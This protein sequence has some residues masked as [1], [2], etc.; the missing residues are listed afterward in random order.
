MATPTPEQLAAV[1][2][3]CFNDHYGIK[4][5]TGVPLDFKNHA[6]LWEPYSDNSPKLVCMK[7]AQIGFSTMAINKS[8]WATKNLGLDTIYT[9]P[10]SNDVKDF[11]S[12]K[13]NRII[14]HNPIFLKWVKDK[15][16][17]E[18]KSIDGFTIYY[19]GCVDE[20]TEVLTKKGWKKHNEVKIG[21]SLY[22]YNLDT[23]SLEEDSIIDLTVFDT[24]EDVV[25]LESNSIDALIT[26]DHRCVVINRNGKAKIQRAHELK[27]GS[28]NYIPI[29]SKGLEKKESSFSNNA[30]VRVLGW[31]ITEGSYWNCRNKSTFVRKDGT[32]NDKVYETPRVSI[33]Q[34]NHC[35][36][37]E[38]DLF[39]AGITY[40][41]VLRK[42]GTY[43]YKLNSKHSKDVVELLP[44]KE[45][46]IDFI[47]SLNTQ[48]MNELIDVMV[49]A[50]GHTTKSGFR[51]FIQKSHITSDAFQYLCTLTGLNT[52]KYTRP[53]REN[54]YS[55]NEINSISIKKSTYA[56]KYKKTIEKYKGIMWC[57]TTRNSTI[58]VRRNGKIHITGQ[59]W[60]ERAALSTSAD[61]VVNDELDR[62]KQEVVEQYESRLQHS[63]YQWRWIFSNPSIHNF[64]AHKYWLISDQMHWFIDCPHCKKKQYLS[65]PENIDIEKEIY[66][67]KHCSG[68]LSDK[69][70]SKGRWI[71]KY[72][73]REWRG[74]WIS[75]LMAP[76]VPASKIIQYAK[77]KSPEYFHNFVLG[78]PYSTPDSKPQEEDILKNVD[79]TMNPQDGTIVIGLDTGLTNWYVLGNDK[80]IFYHGSCEGYDEIEGHLKNYKNSV[81]IADQG[82]DLV[83]IRELREKYPGRVFLCHYRQDRKT[84]QLI[85]WGEK[86]EYGNVVVDRNRMISA[87]LGEF[88]E[89]R[90]PLNGTREDW[91]PYWLHWNN[92][93]KAIEEDKLGVPRGKWERTGPDHLVHATLYWRVGMSKFVGGKAQF[94]GASSLPRGVENSITI[95]PNE[96]YRPAVDFTKLPAEEDDWRNR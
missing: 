63:E 55:N 41:K 83:K 93:Y 45:L 19:R 75:L 90:M 79:E 92:I 59:T 37:L 38:K 81:L 5:E 36:K 7:S 17:V 9:L 95:K 84:Y 43:A 67:C 78:L 58:I 82:G 49:S 31:I 15:D 35:T 20:Q 73:N 26:Q 64:G 27:S 53:P 14:A 24:E 29:A 69:D 57:P 44:N 16:S 62:S 33:I 3:H 12:G 61:L 21:D 50:D 87:I 71:P 85:Q 76:W 68:E 86:K 1:N 48:Q 65:W 96:T 40:T 51:T 42:C 47:N 56:I 89:S 4:T 88:R 70:R 13:V 2:I 66:I 72:K 94:V 54:C 30:Y 23:K 25:R 46:T 74:Y 39:E 32:I 91:Y 8:L 11:V 52:T 10:T 80:G 22:S 18:Q 34:K 6:F 28:N 60:T 77:E